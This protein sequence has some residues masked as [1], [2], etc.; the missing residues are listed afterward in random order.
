[1]LPLLL[2]CTIDVLGFGIMI[3]LI[4]YMADRFGTP[5]ELITPIL[6]TYS[7]CQFIA[8]PIWGRLSDRFGRRPILMLSLA[9]AC[10]SYVILALSSSVE[11]LL[12]SRILAGFMAGNLA[13]AFA[14]ASDLSA[15]EDRARFLG[16]VGAAIGVGFMLGPAIGGALA[17]ENEH[18]AD[19]TLPALVSV[20]LSAL[21]VL[22]VWR[23][24][25]ESH[26][27]RGAAPAHGRS[28]GLALLARRPGLR[29][30]AG[31]E[32][33][34]IFAQSIL[35]SIFA[36]WALHKFGFGPRT[37]GFVL[38]CLAFVAVL[39]QGFLVRFMVLRL[40]E[41]TLAVLGIGTFAVG[42]LMVAVAGALVPTIAG[43]VLC[44]FGAGCYNPSLAALASRQSHADDRGAV[45]GV[46][47]SSAS[48][49]RVIAPFLAGAIFTFLGA[50]MPFVAAACATVPAMLLVW[51]MRRWRAL[52]VPA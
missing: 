49:A 25:P 42:L 14:Y 27:R 47:Q 26:A 44:G 2:V 38:F 39:T 29:L 17:G 34:V 46:Y 32:L 31:A 30:V 21:A 36:I 40:G 20:A 43:L 50:A 10:I 22:L 5:P 11:W 24:L 1:M 37:V 52:P 28:R 7:L 23:V 19:F 18:T 8:A 51:R 6:G 41:I 48:L 9:G 3:P 33:L 35:E 4:P 15:P 45:M 12:L 16:M 13:A